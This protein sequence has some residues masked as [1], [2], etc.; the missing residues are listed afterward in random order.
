M[1]DLKNND[2]IVMTQKGIWKR[3]F[4]YAMVYKVLVVK[5]V[6]SMLLVAAID[7]AYPLLT[8]YVID[9]I[10]ILK[11][12]QYLALFGLIYL[13]LVAVQGFC[14]YYF[15]SR[16][17]KLEMNISYDIRR[18]SFKKLQEI[19]LSYYD[20]T[21]VGFIMARMV[22]DI[23][24][25]SEMIAWSFIDIMWA[26]AFIVGCI[27]T[28]FYLNVKLALIVMI[29]LPLLTAISIYYQKRILACQRE[30]RRQNSK[31]VGAFN[32]GIVGAVTTKTLVR[33]DEN[34]SEFT[35]L[36]SN[37][38]NSSVR[39]AVLSATFLPI[40]MFL[41]SLATAA[42]IG[43]GGNMI[44][45]GT[46]GIGTLAAFITYSTQLFDPIQSLARV[47]A[48]FQ[49]AHASAERVL[50]LLDTP[51]EI[52]EDEEVVKVFGDNFNPIRD[53]WP[54]IKGSIEFKNVSFQY[55][56][57]EKVLENFNLYIKEGETIAFVGE[58]GGGKSTIINLACRFY[59]P[60]SGEILIDG[61]N[62]RKRSSLW[63]EES[64]G[65]VLQSPH[66]FSGTIED[67]I[68]YGCKS[69]TRQQV[70]DAAKTVS[71]HEFIE[72]LPN[73]YETEVGEGGGLLSTGQ[74]QLISFAR[75]VI[76]NPRILVL[77]EATS[78]IDTD[79]ELLLQ[80]AV[81]HVLTGRT[82]LIVAHRLST[83]RNANRILVIGDGKISEQGTHDELMKLRGKYYNLYQNQYKA[84]LEDESVK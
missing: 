21:P 60:T 43:F 58:T 41:G 4:R 47:V 11:N 70:I 34:Y 40:A 16:G 83:I 17:G 78:S 51:L 38:R 73:G 26:A 12:T 25:L 9:N 13:L 10:I 19:S 79:T 35:E 62:Y 45:V 57:G 1:K 23:A 61:V 55:K 84:E 30:V 74:K 48:E 46:I 82:S 32:E 59:E 71:L 63:L 76:A 18:D 72:K 80:N 65:Y 77:D 67:N 37:M 44:M 49:S 20:R 56:D 68:K 22:G 42:A 39:S 81:A 53:N 52:K 54:P 50:T 28:L 69:A 27:C 15:V 14:V 8:R 2:N 5:L 75:V 24:R 66:L 31:I 36:T 3:L 29:I 64:L 33:E 7:T 6:L